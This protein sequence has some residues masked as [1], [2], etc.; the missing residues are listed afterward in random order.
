MKYSEI[1]SNLT[2]AK[3][4]KSAAKLWRLLKLTDRK[5]RDWSEDITNLNMP[6][7]LELAA[8]RL[9]EKVREQA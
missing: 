4:F 9:R 6:E 7:A 1:I 3:S 5:I 2:A 8:D